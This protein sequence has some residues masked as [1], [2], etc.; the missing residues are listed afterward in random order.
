MSKR[1]YN[2]QTSSHRC[3]RKRQ[4]TT[5]TS[6][7]S[8]PSHE[9]PQQ[10]QQQQ[11]QI[12]IYDL[13]D[14]ILIDIL[15]K[16]TNTRIPPFLDFDFK[17]TR[18]L[19]L[20]N[21][22]F[23]RLIQKSEFHPFS[24][25]IHYSCCASSFTINQQFEAPILFTTPKLSESYYNMC[26]KCVKAYNLCNGFKTR[27]YKINIGFVRDV[28]SVVFTLKNGKG[29]HL[30]HISLEDFHMKPRVV[31]QAEKEQGEV[32]DDDDN[33]NNNNEGTVG[34]KAI[35]YPCDFSVIEFLPLVGRFQGIKTRFSCNSLSNILKI[36]EIESFYNTHNNKKATTFYLGL[37]EVF[38]CIAGYFRGHC[39]QG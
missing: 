10:Q 37:K 33:N 34:G 3:F 25:H 2:R 23:N 1:Q 16:T 4:R 14:D 5:P 27:R 29:C 22:K 32:D 30:M 17:L 35:M 11:Q 18:Q 24:V 31:T 28:R 15:D 20:V 13:P 38:L 21:K 39:K 9:E 12:T 7:F 26:Q 36:Q 8:P 6:I 19:S